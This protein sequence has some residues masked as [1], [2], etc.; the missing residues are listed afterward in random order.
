MKL[1]LKLLGLLVGI[2]TVGT[3]LFFWWASAGTADKQ[4][5]ADTFAYDA[6]SATPQ[7]SY[8]IVSY[9]IG[10]L[11]GLANNTQKKPERSFFDANQQRAITALKAVSPDVVAFQEIDFEAS[12]S[13]RVNQMDV[14]AQ[15]LE[16]NAGAIAINWDKNY[17]PFPPGHPQPTSAKFAQAKLL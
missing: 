15:S 4:T 9:N 2:P 10:Y 6:P 16:M 12:R 7:D 3:V 13:Y 5:Y 11:S 17:L 8:T 14:I 1:F